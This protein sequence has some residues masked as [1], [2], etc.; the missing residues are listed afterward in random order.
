MIKIISKDAKMAGAKP[1]VDKKLKQR[2][3]LLFSKTYSPTCNE[4]KTILEGYG[5]KFPNY[6]V[7]EIESRQDCNQIENYFQ[8]LCLTDRRDVPQLFLDGKYVGGEK[9]IHLLH[10]SGDLGKML[11]TSGALKRTS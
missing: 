3:V 5:L 2:K 9:E 4:I 10:K 11:V 8:I 1:F 7:V 6:E